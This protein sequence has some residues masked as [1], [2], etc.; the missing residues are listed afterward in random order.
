[1]N[2]HKGSQFINEWKLTCLS[3][4]ELQYREHFVTA[5]IDLNLC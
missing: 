1:M 2:L 4:K 5:T 3:I